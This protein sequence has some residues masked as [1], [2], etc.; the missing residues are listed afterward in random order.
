MVDFTPNTT[1]AIAYYRVSTARQGQSGLGLQA[2]R[3]SVENYALRN[4]LEISA[5]FTEVETGTRKRQRPVIQE[6]IAAAKEQDALLLIAKLDRLARNV[7]FISSLQESGV[8]FVAVDMPQAN[9]LTVH[10][11]AAI[12]EHEAELISQ[13]TKVALQ[14]AKTRGITLGSPDNLTYAAQVSGAE[15]NKR[16]AIEAYK[17]TV[18]YVK[19]LREHGASYGAIAKRLNREGHVTRTGKQFHAMTVRR[20]LQRTS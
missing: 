3:A 19:L 8:E 6:A 12:A 16:L 2:Q 15:E 13:R 17:T 14:A 5:E 20:M 9:K 4:R 10:I 11:M 18:G 7:A 1:R